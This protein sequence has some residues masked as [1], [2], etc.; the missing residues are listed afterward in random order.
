MLDYK[1]AK[2]KVGLI[3]ETFFPAL[4]EIKGK[5]L[6]NTLPYRPGDVEIETMDE[7]VSQTYAQVLLKK[8]GYELRKVDVEGVNA[9]VV[10]M[11]PQPLMD[12][13]RH[14]RKNVGRDTLQHASEVDAKVVVCQT[15]SQRW[16]S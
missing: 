15:N 2:R 6:I 1:L 5:A 11:N 12:S 8:L 9:T 10:E 7:T 16:T 4:S 13:G 3:T 14:I